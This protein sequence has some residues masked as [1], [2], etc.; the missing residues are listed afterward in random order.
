MTGLGAVAAG[1]GVYLGLW[2]T[3]V[4]E[5]LWSRIL[6]PIGGL[7]AL[8]V[9]GATWIVPES[10]GWL[11]VLKAEPPRVWRVVVDGRRLALG[12]PRRARRRGGR[13]RG[14]SRPRLA[15]APTDRKLNWNK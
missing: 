2:G 14:A 12:R 1:C 15:V 7:L 6:A 5:I 3:D 8:A 13:R 10:R 4:E 11:D 9:G